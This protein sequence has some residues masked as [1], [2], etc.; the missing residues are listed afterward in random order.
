MRQDLGD[1]TTMNRA[2]MIAAWVL[3]LL[4]GLAIAG[5]GVLKLSGDPAMVEMFDDIGAGQWLRLVIGLLEVAGAVG[6]IVPRVRAMAAFCL[7][8]LLLG[9][10]VTNATVLD[11]SPLVSLVLAVVAL[12][13]L[14]LR[15]HELLAKTSP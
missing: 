1:E 9:A 10:T 8:V 13:I 12:A 3:Q 7:L 14:L 15:R 4:L 6:L 11:T 2:A 5:G